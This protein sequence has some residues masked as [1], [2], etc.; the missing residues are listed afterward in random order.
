MGLSLTQPLQEIQEG[1]CCSPPL[2][3][4]LSAPVLLSQLYDELIALAKELQKPGE[5]KPDGMD[6]PS[7][8]IQSM[9]E[10]LSKLPGSNYNTL[11]HLV[12]HLYR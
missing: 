5:E 7:D 2:P 3:L 11:R 10:L 6:F 1:T 4:Q 12:A 9:K 8:P